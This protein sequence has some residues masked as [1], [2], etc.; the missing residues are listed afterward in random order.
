MMI[1]LVAP[2]EA[3]GIGADRNWLLV[4]KAGHMAHH[5]RLRGVLFDDV[6]EAQARAEHELG[7]PVRWDKVGNKAWRAVAAAGCER[8]VE[9][10]LAAPM[11]EVI[12]RWSD[13]EDS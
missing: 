11:F 1:S 10:G 13:Q 7:H 4:I 2:R 6:D 12:A 8:C 9:V 3:G 5:V